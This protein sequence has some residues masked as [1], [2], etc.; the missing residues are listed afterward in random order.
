MPQA[1]SW[2]FLKLFLLW[3]LFIASSI[4]RFSSFSQFYLNLKPLAPQLGVPSRFELLFNNRQKKKSGCFSSAQC[5][6][7]HPCHHNNLDSSCSIHKISDISLLPLQIQCQAEVHLFSAHCYQLT[8]VTVLLKDKVRSGEL[9]TM[10][11]LFSHLQIPLC[12]L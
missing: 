9:G 11:P 7:S 2:L 12:C 6:K 3:G 5:S 1:T 4:P 10:L 8:P